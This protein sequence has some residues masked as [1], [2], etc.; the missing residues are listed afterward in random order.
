MST[1]LI[2]N[3]RRATLLERS[4]RLIGAATLALVLPL[5]LAWSEEVEDSMG[6]VVDL[7]S[8]FK[9][10]GQGGFI[11]QGEADIDGG[12]TVEVNRYDAA[13]AFR[14]DLTE[15][16]SWNNTLFIGVSDYDFEG[17][18]FSEGNPWDTVLLNR[19]GSQVAYQIDE[20]WGVRGGGVFMFSQETGGDWGQGFSGGGMVGVDYRHSE[21]FFVSLGLAVVSQIEDDVRVAP[22]VGLNWLP[23][24]HWT[25]RVGAVP[26]SG[27]AAAAAEVEYAFTEKVMAGL[28]LIYNHRRFRLDD[29]GVAPDGVGEDQNL[30]LRFRVGW[31]ITPQVSLNF[32]AGVVVG[33]Q[34]ELEDRDGNSLRKEDYDPATYFG[35]R[36]IGRF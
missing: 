26:V 27:G 29:S 31:N 2:F 35:V 14:L 19:Y 30:P 9:F 16:W 18:G 11:R 22:S 13:V 21:T 10:L 25:V 8:Q 5:P 4:R 36:A 32:L 15:Q 28:G 23:A 12:G 1:S 34:L 33:G 20:H 3:S 7:P 6:E 17:G 24:E